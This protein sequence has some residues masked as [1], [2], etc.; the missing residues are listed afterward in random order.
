[1]TRID[2]L[3]ERVKR[4]RDSY[5]A[6]G[7]STMTDQEYDAAVEKLH[8]LTGEYDPVVGPTVVFTGKVMHPQDAPMLSMQKVYSEAEIVKW[9][10]RLGENVGD[11][12]VMPKYDGIALR[13][14]NTGVYAT[15]G[16]GRLGENVSG[17]ASR[18]RFDVSLSSSFFIDGEAVC[19]LSDF[20]Q[21]AHLGY[22]N[23]RNAVSGILGSKDQVIQDR[24]RLLTFVPYTAHAWGIIDA[25]RK[26]KW[27]LEEEVHAA[28]ENVK[29]KCSDY[30]MDGI[31]FRVS[32]PQLFKK[33]DHTDH[34]WRGQIA[35]KFK[36]EQAQTTISR[37][38]W[39][40][41][42]GTVTP[43]AILQSVTLDGAAISRV[44]LHNADYVTANA[45]CEGDVVV[46][47]RAGGVIPSVVRVLHGK[48]IGWP[49]IPKE[50][51]VCHSQLLRSGARLY[52]PVC[53]AK[54]DKE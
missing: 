54:G 32:N 33:L 4:A 38:D 53:E 16:D 39:Q 27:E 29:A 28:V 47:E 5:W 3:R 36:G 43:V 7:F 11:L 48:K 9:I 17:T 12:H 40:V 25:G 49:V 42:N 20:P 51:P 34:H 22:K 26:E 14:Y 2:E 44:T 1:M 15:R 19:K 45:V 50:C 31:V 18:I 23:P 10:L 46:I 41:K 24:A 30:P 13:R 8:E 52:C 6:V 21:L 37:I 35:L